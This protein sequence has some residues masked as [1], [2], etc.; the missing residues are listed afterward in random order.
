M[1]ATQ[2]GASTGAFRTS[3]TS[4]IGFGEKLGTEERRISYPDYHYR[5]I[6]CV[7]SWDRGMKGVQL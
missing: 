4:V 3:P 2:S 6:K 5:H 1:S 7:F